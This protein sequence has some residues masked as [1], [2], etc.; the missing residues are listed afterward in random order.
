M[1]KVV[2]SEKIPNNTQVLN[3]Y[4]V[5]KIKD[6]YIEKAYEKICLVI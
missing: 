2:T 5:D 1:Q 3:F 4:F 6:P